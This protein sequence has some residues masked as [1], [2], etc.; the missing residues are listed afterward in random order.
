MKVIT[1]THPAHCTRYIRLYSD[2]IRLYSDPIKYNIRCKEKTQTN[3]KQANRTN[4]YN[5][6]IMENWK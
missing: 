2:F 4:E 3:N 1:E 6:I 5:K